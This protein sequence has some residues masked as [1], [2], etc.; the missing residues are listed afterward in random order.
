MKHIRE[1]DTPVTNSNELHQSTLT[2][3]CSGTYFVLEEKS[4]GIP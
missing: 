1:L 4:K 3:F 2:T